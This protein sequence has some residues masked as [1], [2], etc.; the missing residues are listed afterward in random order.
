MRSTVER[1]AP[2]TEQVHV[3]TIADQ[4]D[5]CLRALDGLNVDLIAEPEA[6]GTGPALALATRQIAR[7]DPEAVIASVH[8]DAYIGD[9]NAYRIAVVAAASWAYA[10]GGLA[11]V[12][13]APTYP[14]TGL[15]Y[16]A[17]GER[18]SRAE[19]QDPLFDNVELTEAASESSAYVSTG[20]VE[21]PDLATAQRFLADQSHLWNLGLF[22]WK[23][24]TFESE[25]A[26]AS[27]TLAAKVVD[28]VEHRVA[29][30]EVTAAGIYR[31]LEKV[32]VEPLIFERT[33][34][35]TVVKASF[36][37]SDVGSWRDLRDVRAESGDSD[38]DGNIIDGNA[39][40]V[41]SRNCMVV[42]RGDRLVALAGA[43]DVVV[44]DTGDAVLVVP[45]SQA[46][47]VKELAER[48]AEEKPNLV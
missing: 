28:V 13:L 46:Q 39:L 19:W 10:S 16:V 18:R 38:V 34:Q 1:V 5:L 41:G 47:L 21:K 48:L 42:A 12:G 4:A 35:L 20:F 23:A 2:L 24:T 43:E 3:V 9:E 31:N 30:D 6:R 17:L 14:A 7:R 8:A 36:P 22:A 32:A 26:E 45:A 25:V 15:G 27:P 29:G 11:T 44:V 40:V 37:W 33:P